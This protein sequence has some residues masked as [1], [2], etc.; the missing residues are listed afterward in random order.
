MRRCREKIHW[1]D[2]YI[3]ILS[4]IFKAN[5]LKCLRELALPFIGVCTYTVPYVCFPNQFVYYCL[6]LVVRDFMIV[7]WTIFFS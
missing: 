5:M 6:E 2:I 3:Y 1:G 7:N 4:E